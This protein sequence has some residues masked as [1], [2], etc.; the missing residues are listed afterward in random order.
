MPNA[1]G[2]NTALQDPASIALAIYDLR[3]LPAGTAVPEIT[4][5]PMYETSWR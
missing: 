5:L 3:Q 1:S 2:R 4:V